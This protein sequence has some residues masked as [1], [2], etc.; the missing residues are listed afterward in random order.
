MTDY[1]ERARAW[2]EAHG[3]D[4]CNAPDFASSDAETEST[5]AAFLRDVAGEAR[6]AEAETYACEHGPIAPA[7]T[8]SKEA[9]AVAGY[10]WCKTPDPTVDPDIGE[11]FHF[12]G[13]WWAQFARDDGRWLLSTLT[14]WEWAGPIPEPRE[15]GKEGANG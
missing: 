6:A 4:R 15:P 1:T 13:E 12:D 8:W 14:A 7:L 3:H 2:I 9:P 11:I 5:L 10:Y